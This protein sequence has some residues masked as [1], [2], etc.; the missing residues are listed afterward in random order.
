MEVTNAPDI[1][2]MRA[3]ALS[4]YLAPDPCE[5]ANCLLQKYCKNHLLISPDLEV[6]RKLIA[7]F[8]STDALHDYLMNTCEKKYRLYAQI[9]CRQAMTCEQVDE[10]LRIAL[11]KVHTSGDNHLWN[12]FMREL[13]NPQNPERFATICKEILTWKDQGIGTIQDELEHF[14]TTKL[15]YEVFPSPPVKTSEKNFIVPECRW[16]NQMGYL[17][18]AK[19]RQL[20]SEA[21][22]ACRRELIGLLPSLMPVLDYD[23]SSWVDA[24]V[25]D[26]EVFTLIHRLANTSQWEKKLKS[27]LRK[28]PDRILLL[29]GLADCPEHAPY[30][31][32]MAQSVPSI[33]LLQE[34]TEKLFSKNPHVARDLWS[35]V[36]SARINEPAVLQDNMGGQWIRKATSWQLNAFAQTFSAKMTTTLLESEFINTNKRQL[37][38]IAST[39]AAH[40]DG[41]AGEILWAKLSAPQFNFH[42]F[43]AILNELNAQDPEEAKSVVKTILGRVDSEQLIEGLK[44]YLT[45]FASEHPAKEVKSRTPAHQRCESALAI[46]WNADTL[47]LPLIE[48]YREKEDQ[49][50]LLVL[51]NS[52]VKSNNWQK[53]VPILVN[54]LNTRC[55]IFDRVTAIGC[56]ECTKDQLRRDELIASILDSTRPPIEFDA[57]GDLIS[58]YS[59]SLRGLPQSL[60]NELVAQIRNKVAKSASR[61]YW[62][63]A[64]T[65]EQLKIVLDGMQL[66]LR[67]RQCECY[68]L[69]KRDKKQ[70]DNDL[71]IKYCLL[72]GYYN[73]D[74]SGDQRGEVYEMAKSLA[75]RC[76]GIGLTAEFPSQMLV[77]LKGEGW[78]GDEKLFESYHGEELALAAGD[79]D[80]RRDH[81]NQF[82]KL[83]PQQV[84]VILPLLVSGLEQRE[85]EQVVEAYGVEPV[86]ACC[87]YLSPNQQNWLRDCVEKHGLKLID[88]VSRQ[89]SIEVTVAMLI[90]QIADAVALRKSLKN[91][92][93][94]RKQLDMEDSLQVQRCFDEMVKSNGLIHKLE[95]KWQEAFPTKSPL[96]TELPLSLAAH[97]N[98]KYYRGES[99]IFR[100][101]ALTSVLKKHH[102]TR[103]DLENQG[104]GWWRAQFILYKDLPS[105]VPNEVTWL[106][107]VFKDHLVTTLEKLNLKDKPSI[108]N[109]LREFD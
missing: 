3:T 50:N 4:F 65:G 88:E 73:P 64:L 98:L 101:E 42:C 29:T 55:S 80:Y 12:S 47:L 28:H 19:K 77:K 84:P 38:L 79:R 56:I 37:R 91:I 89:H 94:I 51:L 97:T 52:L 2:A 40:P 95:R 35:K 22:T 68:S 11:K 6:G 108:L 92:L 81:L 106:K 39:L 70:P 44:A 10:F 32:W 25:I 107:A 17:S 76:P 48:Y 26:E 105:V 69:K 30:L 5:K 7:C 61:D 74:L 24:T 34:F 66:D 71:L 60:F 15:L 102:L 72:N 16:L 75:R 21:H 57:V 23:L 78:R 27:K 53:A 13:W 46:F 8:S 109:Y 90:N 82:L 41:N 54:L 36:I 20:W 49:A 103:E 87:E 62:F 31:D 18:D 63:H 67:F 100:A 83:D 43:F 59:V 86:F 14:A 58:S 45:E 85:F 33:D 99:A 9:S 93:A 104:G 1:E 96:I